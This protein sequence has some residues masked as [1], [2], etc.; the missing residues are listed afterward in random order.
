VTERI[1]QLVARMQ[2]RRRAVAVAI[3]VI[4]VV[5]I[6]GASLAVIAAGPGRMAEASATP[7]ASPSLS[8]SL[9]PSPTPSETPSFEPTE[10]G[11]TA[12]PS[13]WDYSDLDGVPAPA[14]KAHRLPMAIM[15]DDNKVAR[16]QSGISTA[17]I[18]Y[19]AMADGGE[20]R[21]MMIWQEGDATDIGPVRSARP[22]FVYWAAEYKALFGHFGGDALSL[23]QTI[24]QMA[25]YIYNED[26]LNGGSCPYHRVST[27]AAPHN[28]YTNTNILMT[29]LLKRGYP[30]TF[31]KTP[32]RP[33]VD[34]TLA[35]DLPAAQNINIPYRT[36][37]IGYKFDPA[38]DSYLRLVSGTVELDPANNQQVHA[39]NVVIMYQAYAMVP[40]IDEMRPV[41][42]N[43]GSGEAI[44][45][46]EGKAIVG[47]WKKTSTTAVT[48]LY[49][50]S[51]K[52]IP[53]V[54]GSIFMQSVPI[55]TGV[56]YDK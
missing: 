39:R 49:D 40:S 23:Q 51:G 14:D 38:T 17:S 26:D 44:V 34:D 32:G 27:R 18:V 4:A 29:C 54:R 50:K 55:G 13:G 8:P 6:L 41:V 5:A 43:V 46:K 37:Q 1:R 33:F 36:G 9:S 2:T 7:S 20:D 12:M 11:P 19:Q 15:V 28:A 31:Q 25:K 35:A 24:P 22:Y 45:F 16:P 56:T 3:G 30:A 47:T 21:Y 52:E 42:G 53:F 48:R 10:F